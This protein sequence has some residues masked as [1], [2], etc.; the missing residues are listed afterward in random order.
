VLHL[1]RHQHDFSAR[2]VDRNDAFPFGYVDAHSSDWFIVH[3]QASQH[4]KWFQ[5]TPPLP[6]TDSACCVT[7]V[8]GISAP[9]PAQIER[10]NGRADRQFAVGKQ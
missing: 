9:Q 2:A 1:E 7:R 8:Y 4:Q 5:P 10:R 3:L 6:I